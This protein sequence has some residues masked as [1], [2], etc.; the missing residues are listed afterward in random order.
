[1]VA[2]VND[3]R[4][5]PQNNGSDVSRLAVLSFPPKRESKFRQSMAG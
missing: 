3:D 2:M 1:M 5:S 4:H